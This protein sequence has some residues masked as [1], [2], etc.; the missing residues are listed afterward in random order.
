MCIFAHKL[1]WEMVGDRLKRHHDEKTT[2]KK[3][4]KNVCINSLHMQKN[5]WHVICGMT[6]V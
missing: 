1:K 2:K 4:S 3:S 6:L 5:K